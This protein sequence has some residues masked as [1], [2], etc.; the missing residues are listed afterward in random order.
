MFCQYH[1]LF[2]ISFYEN[3]QTTV[4]YNNNE[5]AS[6]NYNKNNILLPY[7]MQGFDLEICVAR[8]T[9]VGDIRVWWGG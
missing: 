2:C 1:D 8:R 9:V 7:S 5:I 6:L 3:V 4:Q